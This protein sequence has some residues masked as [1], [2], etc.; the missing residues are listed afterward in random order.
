MFVF[1]YDWAYHEKYVQIPLV[2]QTVCS[3]LDNFVLRADFGN[4]V[5][6]SGLVLFAV[7]LLF[8]RSVGL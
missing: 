1:D 6:K 2:G 5:V 3:L 4:V 7:L 8:L